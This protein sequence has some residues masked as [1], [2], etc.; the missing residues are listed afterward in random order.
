M[1]RIFSLLVVLLLVTLCSSSPR[2]QAGVDFGVNTPLIARTNVGNTFSGG[3]NIFD[4]SAGTA[5]VRI[6]VAGSGG[7]DPVLDI[8]QVASVATRLRLAGEA[9]NTNAYMWTNPTSQSSYMG[10]Y[11]T[12]YILSSGVVQN[13]TLALTAATMTAENSAN[14]RTTVHSYTWTNAQVV[15]L[16]AVNAGDITVATLPA[17]TVVENVYTI[18]VTPDSSANNLTVACGRTGASFIDYIVAS[19]A[20]AAAN[21]VYGDASGERGTNLTGYD[22]PSYTSTTTVT[23]HFIKTTTTLNTV[24]GSTGRVILVTTLVP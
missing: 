16:G 19:D 8:Y 2:V 22:L 10:W 5:P 1:R 11:S 15:A 24:V 13:A 18:I 4:A 3:Q 7:V 9:G 14:Y 23:C 12:F 20:K 6:N 17:K 21:T